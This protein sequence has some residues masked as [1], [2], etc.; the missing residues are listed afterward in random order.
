VLT[1]GAVIAL[2]TLIAGLAVW[3]PARR[4]TGSDPLIALR[5]E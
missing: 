5:A 2:L 3:V 1:Q 4:A